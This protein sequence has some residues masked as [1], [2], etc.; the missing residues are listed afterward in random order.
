[1]PFDPPRSTLTRTYIT[2]LGVALVLA[3]I[4]VVVADSVAVAAMVATFGLL[5]D[6]AL[7]LASFLSERGGAEQQIG[8]LTL[9]ELA[10]GRAGSSWGPLPRPL[11]DDLQ[12]DVREQRSEVRVR[13]EQAVFA[14]AE[15]HEQRRVAPGDLTA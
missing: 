10:V 4:A 14:V 5:A 7:A 2:I 3:L 8:W 11:S 12:L 1:M 6:L 13:I 9:A 15:Q